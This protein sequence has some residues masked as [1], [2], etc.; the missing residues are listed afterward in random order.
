MCY[1]VGI[2]DL[3]SNALIELIEQST[4]RKVSFKD[5]CKY[6]NAVVKILN[7]PDGRAVL[8]LSRDRTDSF[9]RN[10]T[11]YFDIEEDPVTRDMTIAL[12]K[13]YSPDDLRRIFRVAMSFEMVLAFTDVKALRALGC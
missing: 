8:V 3:V 7:N 9:L 6:G 13:A 12:K 10:W 1:Y 11:E 5:L 4:R 2:E